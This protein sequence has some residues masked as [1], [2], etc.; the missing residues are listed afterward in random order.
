MFVIKEKYKYTLKEN[1]ELKQKLLQ[2]FTAINIFEE[3]NFDT[4]LK[5]NVKCL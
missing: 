5:E 1:N 4:K 3:S 2:I